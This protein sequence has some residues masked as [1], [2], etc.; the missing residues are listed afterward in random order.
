MDTGGSARRAVFEIK[1][2][3][4]V[5]SSDRVLRALVANER[6]DPEELLATQRR[7]AVDHA[8]F[9]MQSTRFYRDLYGDAG[10]TLADLH[11]PEVFDSLPVVTK[12]QV[13]ERFDD[14]VTP[15]ATPRTSAV[16]KTGGSTGEPTRILRDTRVSAQ[17]FEWRLFRWW[18]VHPADN[19]VV[20]FRQVK[21]PAEQLKHAVKWWPTR[22]VLMDAYNLSDE[23][24]A[25]FAEDW[26]RLRPTLVTGY[27]GGILS[28]ARSIDRLGLTPPPLTAL[29]TTASPLTAEARSDVER[30]FGA[31]VYDH[32][33]SSEM[34][35]MG[36]ECIERQGHHLFVEGRYLQLVDDADDL[37]PTGEEGTVVATDLTNRVFP[38]IRYRL[39]DRTRAIPA[40]CS[41]GVTLPRFDRI[42]GRATDGIHLPDGTWVPGIGLYQLFNDFPGAVRQFQVDQRADYSV[43]LRCVAGPS[44]ETERSVRAA[45]RLLER[46]LHRKVPVS[47]EVVPVIPDV[48]GKVQYVRTAVVP[49]SSG[50]STGSA[51]PT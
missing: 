12:D 2:R 30:V 16:S 42:A 32:Y 46:L 4:A 43:V 26:H 1:R 34:P 20:V 35:W 28:I 48:G 21:S 6:R 51:P 47:W 17:P 44:P 11:D 25:K 9:A 18:G 15:E 45:T 27:A 13:R 7:R 41:C 23:V 14:F 24:V 10:L 49:A 37:V 39:G 31:P 5:R 36:G 19:V 38:L 22:R 3:T 50:G 29:A 8:R 33:R 40:P